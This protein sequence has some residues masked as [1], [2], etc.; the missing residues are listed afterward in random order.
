MAADVDERRLYATTDAAVWAEE[1]KKVCPE[2]DEGLML[3][4]FANAIETGRNFGERGMA[5]GPRRQ[6]LNVINMDGGR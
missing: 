2:V 3:G 4:W 5:R 1:F 6:V